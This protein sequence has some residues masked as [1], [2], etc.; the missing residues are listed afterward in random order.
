MSIITDRINQKIKRNTAVEDSLKQIEL[1]KA[2]QDSLMKEQAIKDSTE[3][4]VAE[5]LKTVNNLEQA[6]RLDSQYTVNAPVSAVYNNPQYKNKSEEAI[7]GLLHEMITH[8]AG[9]NVQDD[10][11][12]FLTLKEELLNVHAPFQNTEQDRMITSYAA[13]H[14]AQYEYSNLMGKEDMINMSRFFVGANSID[15]AWPSNFRP[16]QLVPINDFNVNSPD[17]RDINTMVESHLGDQP[18]TEHPHNF[19]EATVARMVAQNQDV[20]DLI[21]GTSS[22]DESQNKVVITGGFVDLLK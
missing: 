11:R 3:K 5:R 2:L 17:S 18:Y 15:K 20:I 10:Y 19:R 22:F 4:V 14:H 9:T 16:T 1:Q 6:K 13:G 8:E 21:L 12:R 7:Y